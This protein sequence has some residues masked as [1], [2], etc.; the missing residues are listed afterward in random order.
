MIIL[1]R[2][3]Q[4]SVCHD[5]GLVG[6]VILDDCKAAM[7]TLVFLI[8]VKCRSVVEPSSGLNFTIAKL[9]SREG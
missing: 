7:V 1:I 2:L 8:L 3:V 4:E 6:G 5:Y 9:G